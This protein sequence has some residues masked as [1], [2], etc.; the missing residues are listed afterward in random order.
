MHSDPLMPES[1]NDA[2]AAGLSSRTLQL[3]KEEVD[4]QRKLSFH[5]NIVRFIGACCQIPQ[6]LI[7]EPM[8]PEDLPY[9]RVSN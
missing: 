8:S 6:Q 4:L 2:A 3:F 9:L 1:D 7:A 5:P